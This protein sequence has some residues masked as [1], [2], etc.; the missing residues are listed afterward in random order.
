MTAARTLLI[1][2]YHRD[3]DGNKILVA[4]GDSWVLV[5]KIFD[6]TNTADHTIFKSL[7]MSRKNSNHHNN[8]NF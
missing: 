4:G 3:G 1:V 2:G 6:R 8:M 7:L 5:E